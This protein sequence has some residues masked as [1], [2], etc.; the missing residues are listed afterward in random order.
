MVAKTTVAI[1]DYW[2]DT[3]VGYSAICTALGAG[4][5]FNNESCKRLDN[6]QPMS[7]L[8]QLHYPVDDSRLDNGLRVLI[9]PDP[10]AP[11]VA[12]NLWYRVGSADELTGGTG[13]AHLFE[14]LMF[15]GSA[16]VTSG[17][18]LAT[19][20]AVGGSANAT[21]S[22][23][24]TN[25]FETVG[26]QALELALWL[27]ADRM[28]SLNVD[29]LNLDTQRDV[30]KEEKRQRYDNV[31]YGDQ[32]QLLLELNFPADHPYAHPPIGSMAD[33]D[34]ATLADVQRFYQTW[35]Q[36]A[37]AVL[38][39]AGR[40]TVDQGRALAERYFGRL[41]A[42][43]VPPSCAPAAL[44]T[45]TGLPELTVTRA[46]PR[47]MIHLCWRTPPVT[48]GDRMALELLLALLTGG[49]SARL[50][51][52]LVRDRELAEGIGGFDFGLVQGSSLAVISARPRE[53]VELAAIAEPILTTL[54]A[55][56]EQGPTQA[57]LN[58]AK[59]GFER[60]WLAALA[61][62][63]DRADQLGYYATHF[64][65]PLRINRELAEIEA[66]TAEEIARAARDWLAP[67]KRATLRYLVGEN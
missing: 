20:Q 39:L 44:P 36:P 28:A 23:D 48:A 6:M 29:Q 21:T 57:E 61:P 53:G 59:A 58:R 14:H 12:V 49:Q 5:H 43:E 37:G 41:P 45:H 40:I 25:Y 1:A 22:F 66:I 67:D 32:L 35:Y 55:L 18:H 13:F 11:G 19:I 52:E 38:T 15:A 64:D 34:A 10:Q 30:V 31:P 17:E 47:P 16:N 8:L 46:V 51:R 27:E 9:N 42:R 33:L 24:R 50:N 3:A 7:E 4:R 60:Q 54:T 26:P 2:I 63:E 62:V 65:D 56:A